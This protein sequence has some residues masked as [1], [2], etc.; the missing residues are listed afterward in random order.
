[1][2][3]ADL[4]AAMTRRLAKSATPLESVTDTAPRRTAIFG[5]SPGRLGWVPYSTKSD[6]LRSNSP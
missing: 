1:M 6:G 4:L 5:A 3:T 2:E